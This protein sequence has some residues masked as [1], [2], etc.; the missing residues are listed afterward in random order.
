MTALSIYGITSSLFHQLASGVTMGTVH[1]GLCHI[2]YPYTQLR[3]GLRP[4]VL[5][6][7]DWKVITF[8]YTFQQGVKDKAVA[9][10]GRKKK[11][12]VKNQNEW[13]Y[14]RWWQWLGIKRSSTSSMCFVWSEM[15]PYSLGRDG[16]FLITTIFRFLLISV[17]LFYTYSRLLD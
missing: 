10:F 5:L 12:Y 13:T 14:S 9:H 11:L 15:S 17:V 6:G 8:S 3:G 16:G 2:T 1:L 4:H 7:A